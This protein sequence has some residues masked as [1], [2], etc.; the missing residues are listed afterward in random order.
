MRKFNVRMAMV[1]ISV[2]WSFGKIGELWP[3]FSM[4][5]SHKLGRAPVGKRYLVAALMCNVHTCLYGS[6]TSRYFDC[7]SPS[8]ESYLAGTPDA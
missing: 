2:E 3:W 6:N 8:L 5:R 4:A 1:R 7:P